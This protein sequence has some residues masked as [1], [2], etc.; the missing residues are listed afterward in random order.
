MPI[1]RHTM[2]HRTWRGGPDDNYIDERPNKL[3]GRQVQELAASGNPYDRANAAIW[4]HVLQESNPE[5]FFTLL[6]NLMQDSDNDVHNLACQS[7]EDVSDEYI[8]TMITEGEVSRQDAGR[9][10]QIYSEC[11]WTREEDPLG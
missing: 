4:I 2:Q 6:S 10:A 1:V 11:T 3:D 9:L 5:L 8:E 7:F